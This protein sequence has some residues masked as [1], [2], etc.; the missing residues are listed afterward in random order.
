MLLSC[1]VGEDSFFFFLLCRNTVYSNDRQE[2]VAAR[3]ESSQVGAGQV[4]TPPLV[5]LR[6]RPPRC[7][8]QGGSTRP[9]RPPVPN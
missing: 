5:I 1:G 8:H 7:W 2:A 4:N 3:G 9:P 6:R